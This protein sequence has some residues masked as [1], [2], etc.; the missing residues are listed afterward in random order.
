MA[1]YAG[2]ANNNPA[3]SA[4]ADEAVTVTKANT[5]T[6][7][8]I[9]NVTNHTVGV[10]SVAL[11]STV[12]DKATVTG[13]AAIAA[14]GNVT[15]TFYTTALNCTG[16]S[17]GA[18]SVALVGNPG[19][20]HPSASQGPLAVGAYSFQA[21]YPGDP[22][23][24]AST[25]VCEPLTVNKANPTYK[26]EAARGDEFLM[27]HV[28]SIVAEVVAQEKHPEGKDALELQNRLVS[29]AIRIHNTNVLKR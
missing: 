4:C 6:V 3:S 13:I 24:N 16:T 5:T 19:V 25:S 27:R 29:E 2:D 8:E 26:A 22:N 9:H 1:D 11:G 10:T 12:D 17:V 28:I 20:A 7:T 18:G 21:S 15:F 14:T 23:Y